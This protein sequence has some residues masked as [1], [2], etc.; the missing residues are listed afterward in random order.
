MVSEKE[1]MLRGELFDV[2]DVELVAEREKAREMLFILSNTFE[3]S[4]RKDI[5]RDLL[6]STKNQFQIESGFCCDYGYNIHLGENFYA[7]VGFTVLDGAEVRFGDNVLI[8]PNV[9]I[10]TAE[11]PLDVEQ[12]IAGLEYNFPVIVGD[13]VWIGADVT[14]I[15]GVTIGNNTVIGAGSVVIKDVPANVVAVGNPCRIVR[16]IKT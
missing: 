7:N 16:E 13:N 9:G 5:L 1:K 3:R 2:T 11:H 15:G 10:Y 12:R 14:I 8:G 6:G 4:V